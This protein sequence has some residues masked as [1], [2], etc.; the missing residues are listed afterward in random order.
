MATVKRNRP[1]DAYRDPTRCENSWCHKRLDVGTDWLGRVVFAPC[2]HCARL[3]RGVCYACP[4]KLTP[5]T[6]RGGSRWC[7]RCHN[8][9]HAALKREA[10]RR[11]YKKPKNRTRERARSATT[12][13]DARPLVLGALRT[14]RRRAAHEAGTPSRTVVSRTAACP[15][16]GGVL[17]YKTSRPKRCDACW[18]READAR[19]ARSA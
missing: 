10:N 16:C 14:Q 8:R 3:A 1:G 18:A 4:V 13:A 7:T 12:Y 6:R 17:R 15:D 2:A 9:R 11:W 5:Q 19:R